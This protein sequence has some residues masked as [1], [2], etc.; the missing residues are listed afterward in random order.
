M[1]GGLFWPLHSQSP[2]VIYVNIKSTVFP[3]DGIKLYNIECWDDYEW[4]REK[5]MA[6]SNQGLYLGTIIVF[7]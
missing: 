1:L 7:S 5:G 6:W 2:V 3:S 4:W